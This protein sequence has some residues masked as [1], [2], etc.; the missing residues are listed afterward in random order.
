VTLDFAQLAA[1]VGPTAAVLM[2]MY[3]NRA[4]T[5]KEKAADPMQKLA[6]K[7]NDIQETVN[8]TQDRVISVQSDLNVLKDRRP[9]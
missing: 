1:T 3:L 4:P 7:L 2:F 5:A 8:D 6:D 9:R